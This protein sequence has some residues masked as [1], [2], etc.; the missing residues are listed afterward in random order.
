MRRIDL[1]T[2]LRPSASVACAGALLLS[3]LAG[4]QAYHYTAGGTM[5]STDQY[6]YESTSWMP[7]TVAVVDTRTGQE[8]LVVEVPV[9]QKL[10][11]NF[12]SKA[13]LRGLIGTSNETY[14][15][16]LRWDLWPRGQIFGEPM[17]TIDVPG[18][19]SRLID[20]RL[21]PQPE[22]PRSMQPAADTAPADA[23]AGM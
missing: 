1:S 20:V 13:K 21:R 18:P 2:A 23:D 7:Q 19:E 10:V 8:L 5:A 12:V 6:A 3:A 17:K 14:P 16:T 15:E 9:G 22:L 11:M 4:C